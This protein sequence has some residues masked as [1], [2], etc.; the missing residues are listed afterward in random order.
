MGNQTS[1]DPKAALSGLT[2]SER[3]ALTSLFESAHDANSQSVTPASLASHL[4]PI[5]PASLRQ[6]IASLSSRLSDGKGKTVSLSGLAAAVRI[7]VFGSVLEKQRL[8]DVYATLI[9][10]AGT[11]EFVKDLAAGVGIGVNNKEAHVPADRFVDFLLEKCSP[12]TNA[13]EDLFN[14]SNDT[15]PLVIPP[16]S[17]FCTWFARNTYLQVLWDA[18]FTSAFFGTDSTTSTL[19]IP[20]LTARSTLLTVEDLFIL[21]SNMASEFKQS[22]EWV[23]RF[24]SDKHGKSWTVF[25]NSVEDCGAVLVA[26]RDKDGHI[27]G[28]FASKDFKLNPK[29]Y[30][31]STSFVFSLRPQI[32]VYLPTGYNDHYQ[33]FNSG[34]QTLPNGMG[35]GGQLNYFGLWIDASFESG[36]SK[37]EPKSTTY[38]SPRLSK[39][40]EFTIDFVEAWL[41]KP[42]EVDERLV[43]KKGKK[44]VLDDDSTAAMLEM[45]GRRLYSKEIGEKKKEE[46]EEESKDS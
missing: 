23:Q 1:K 3:K 35:F 4:P 29:F 20:T 45:G 7:I 39:Q 40:E 43:T 34:T 28:G 27:F 26:V 11:R 38:D 33:Y 10:P 8:V 18:L 46:D 15:S 14:S 5:L 30:G 9:E 42:K 22:T 25:M 36:H 19:Q 37:A 32:G 12:S 41:I 24:A 13:T 44:S 16:L 21:H 2:D 17:E 31:D 6:A